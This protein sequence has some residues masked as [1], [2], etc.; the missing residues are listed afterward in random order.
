MILLGAMRSRQ[1][2][3]QAWSQLTR[4]EA[5]LSPTP[6]ALALGRVDAYALHRPTIARGDAMDRT[7]PKS[8]KLQ[9]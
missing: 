3:L 1:E 8:T 5:G 9:P 4:Q 6:N 7:L 2:A